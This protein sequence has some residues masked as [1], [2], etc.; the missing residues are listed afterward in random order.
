[1]LDL[2]LGGLV[3]M[4]LDESAATETN[5]SALANNFSRVDK[6]LE[7]VIVH[8]SQSAA[9]GEKVQ[10]SVSYVFGKGEHM[11]PRGSQL[12]RDV[13]AWSLL[14]RLGA[15]LSGR[16]GQDGSLCNNHNVL[17]AELLLQLTNNTVL[18]LLESLQ[19]WDRHVDDDGLLA[20]NIDLLGA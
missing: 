6:V 16:L 5:A 20:G 15:D 17:A 19:L 10:K 11:S 12:T 14:L 7:H 2:S 1:M 4:N 8:D 3:E 18:D 13:P 9:R